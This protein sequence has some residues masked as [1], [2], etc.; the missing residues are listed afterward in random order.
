MYRFKNHRG[1]DSFFERCVVDETLESAL[2]Q[3]FSGEVKPDG[4]AVVEEVDVKVLMCGLA[5]YS[6]EPVGEP[7]EPWGEGSG[8]AL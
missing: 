2:V 4:A 8:F 6:D 7:V 1:G 3:F 5:C